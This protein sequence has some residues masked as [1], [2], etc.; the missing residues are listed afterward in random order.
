[1]LRWLRTDLLFFCAG[2]WGYTMA[3]RLCLAIPGS[4][5]N[6]WAFMR[7]IDDLAVSSIKFGA[8]T[9]EELGGDAVVCWCGMAVFRRS[10]GSVLYA[11]G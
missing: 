10:A 2:F 8:L 7:I 9:C 6:T 3:L 1:M 11:P 4:A 5:V